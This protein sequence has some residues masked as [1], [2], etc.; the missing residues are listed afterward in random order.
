[1]GRAHPN[2]FCPPCVLSA[3]SEV[4]CIYICEY[5]ILLMTC[6]LYLLVCTATLIKMVKARSS[7]SKEQARLDV[8]VASPLLHDR[9]SS[10]EGKG[11]YLTL[12][13]KDAKELMD[14]M[15]LKM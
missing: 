9:N 8:L 1:M 11:A 5:P 13:G 2:L 4:L 14:H 6:F 7:S 10:G 3:M 12:L 15:W